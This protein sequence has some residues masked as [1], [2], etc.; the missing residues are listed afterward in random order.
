MYTGGCKIAGWWA[1][2]AMWW[3]CVLILVMMG[4]EVVG[5][6]GSI[7]RSPLRSSNGENSGENV[8]ELLHRQ[9]ALVESSRNRDNMLLSQSN[10]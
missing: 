2:V 5:C 8:F 10:S 4:V 6:S 7:V 9:Y 1:V 3:W